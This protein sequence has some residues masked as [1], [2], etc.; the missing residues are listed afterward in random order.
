[1]HN[2]EKK[3]IRMWKKNKIS[4][5]KKRMYQ[6]VESRIIKEEEEKAERGGEGREKVVIGRY[7]TKLCCE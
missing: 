2:A 5:G 4:E 1:M 7:R 3:N 6:K